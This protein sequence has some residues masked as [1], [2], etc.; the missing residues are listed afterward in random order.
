MAR[1][2]SKCGTP[3]LDAPPGEVI[4]V[5]G[6]AAFV[7][8]AFPDAGGDCPCCSSTIACAP[9]CPLLNLGGK[10]ISYLSSTRGRGDSPVATLEW[11]ERDSRVDAGPGRLVAVV[12]VKSWCPFCVTACD[13]LSS[14]AWGDDSD[15]D[16]DGVP[17]PT[18]YQVDVSKEPL[19]ECQRR[20]LGGAEF[21]HLPVPHVAAFVGGRRISLRGPACTAA[22]TLLGL[23][24]VSSFDLYA[25]RITSEAARGRLVIDV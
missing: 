18:V 24:A 12:F 14:M 2:C 20:L 11:L 23:R 1:V 16:D 7:L 22:G 15:Q 6:A 4:D 21:D 5:A 25:P 8:P 19:A 9:A 17:G 13:R 10:V 3:V